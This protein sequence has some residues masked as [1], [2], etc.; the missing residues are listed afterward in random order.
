MHDFLDLPA[1]KDAC[2][3]SVDLYTESRTMADS[4]KIESPRSH[5]DDGIRRD[6]SGHPPHHGMS[7]GQYLATR[8]TSLKPPMLKAPNPF[9]L[10]AKITGQQWAFFAVA[11]IAWVRVTRFRR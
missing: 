11:F 10:L 3:P 9:R 7:A 4:E 1:L 2:L 8:F 6:V 5:E